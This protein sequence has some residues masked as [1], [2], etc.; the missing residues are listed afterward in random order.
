MENSLGVAKRS[1]HMNSGQ[2]CWNYHNLSEKNVF[3]KKKW[4]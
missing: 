1:G 3:L 4:A 2:G